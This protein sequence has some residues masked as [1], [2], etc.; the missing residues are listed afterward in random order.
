MSSKWIPYGGFLI[1]SRANTQSIGASSGSENVM[2]SKL[3]AGIRY[4]VF[5]HIGFNFWV[6]A[7]YENSAATAS[8]D[9]EDSKGSISK[10]TLEFR[11]FSLSVFL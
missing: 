6:K 8:A 1:A 3:M 2:V 9:G 4:M 5:P 11:L 7:S 10:L